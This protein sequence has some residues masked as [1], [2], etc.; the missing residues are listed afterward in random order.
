M[1]FRLTASIIFEAKNLEEA[2]LLLSEHFTAL[3]ENEVTHDIESNLKFVG[4]INIK[5]FDKY[6]YLD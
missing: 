3:E 1:N 5:P 4:E 2:F 6:T